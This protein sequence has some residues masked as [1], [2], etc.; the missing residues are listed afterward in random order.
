M[1]K[2]IVRQ[3]FFD[4]GTTNAAEKETKTCSNLPGRPWMQAVSFVGLL[5][6]L[7][8][9]A[10]SP[11]GLEAHEIDSTVREQ[12]ILRTRQGAILA[13]TT[14]YHYRNT[15]LHLQALRRSD[16]RFAVNTKNP[17]ARVLLDQPALDVYTGLNAVAREAFA[18]MV[19]E[20]TDCKAFFF[21]LFMPG[22]GTYNVQQFRTSG[23]SVTWQWQH[24]GSSRQVVLQS[25]DGARLLYLCLPSE[26]RSV[27]YGLRYWARD[28]LKLIG[29]FFREGR[30][31]VMYPIIASAH[32]MPA[33]EIACYILSLREE[34]K[35]WTTLSLRDLIHHCCEQ[36][37]QPL[38]SLFATIRWLYGEHPGQMVLIPTSRSFATLTA[39][40][41]QREELELRS[42]FRD[43]QGRYISHIRLHSSIGRLDHVSTPKATRT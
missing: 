27:L 13:R 20:N 8:L 4:T 42:Y 21:D 36:L 31:T 1:A 38:A 23:C 28:E 14:L 30:G 22:T 41:R 9:V 2:G 10:E 15:L 6:M 32:G 33:S 18:A 40:S 17:Y 16:R 35:E 34:G 25:N 26:I 3:S 29:E 24:S 5:R 11:E 12:G 37:R 7:H 39:R 19:F 43:P